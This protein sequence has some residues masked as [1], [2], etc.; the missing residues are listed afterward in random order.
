M[1]IIIAKSKFVDMGPRKIREVVEVIKHL[2]PV[3]AV[4]LLETMPRVAA[5]PLAKTIKQALAN[6]AHNNKIEAG[7]L[8]L[9][10]V[11]VDG[12]RGIKRLDKSHGSRF[13]RG[14]IKKPS[15]HITVILETEGALK[16]V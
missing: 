13:N 10:S 7:Q 9:K 2:S 3:E 15:S 16:K 14:I 12:G 11:S 8:R 5:K 1:A 4:T 6:A